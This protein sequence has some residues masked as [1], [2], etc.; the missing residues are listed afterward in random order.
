MERA[1]VFIVRGTFKAARFQSF[2]VKY[3]DSTLT[4]KELNASALTVYKGKNLP[5]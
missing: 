5:A 4:M 1:L 3:Q 2:V